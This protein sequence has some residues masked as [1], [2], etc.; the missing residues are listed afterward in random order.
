MDTRGKEATPLVRV[1]DAAVKAKTGKTWEQW[2][3]VLDQE[4]AQNLNHQEIV[5]IVRT[6]Y[7]LGSW[8]QQMVTV[9]YEQ[10]RGMRVLHE[11][12]NCFEISVS[13]TIKIPIGMAFLLFHDPKLR[14]RWM[15]DPDFQI[16]KATENKSIR[17]MWVDG[18]T[19]VT[20]AFIA[21][22]TNKTQIA[23]QHDKLKSAKA[24]DKQKA[25]WSE[26]LDKLKAT[27]EG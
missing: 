7:K 24:A 15:K 18:E 25:Y 14:K 19:V 23:V 6:K 4:G 16:R 26:Q 1:G 9:G 13:K 22:A 3:A 10:A 11:K 2:C 21:K 27:V 5:A 8:W 20:V 12:P 17:L